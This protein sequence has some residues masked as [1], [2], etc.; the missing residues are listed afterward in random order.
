MSFR[1][2]ES[3]NGA[4]RKEE[5]L[6]Q[7]LRETGGVIVAFSGGVDSTYLLRVAQEEL[8][9]A[10][11][12]LTTSSPTAPQGDEELAR[13]LAREW[14]VTHVVVDANELEIP[15][16]A[17]NPI[18]RCYF[19]KGSLYEI[20]R[21]EAERRGIDTIVDGVNRDDLGDYRPGLTAA[22]EA[23]VVHPLVEADLSKAEIRELSRR[24]G[25]ETAEKPS[26]PC[27]S[28]RFPYGTEITP[29]RLAKVAAAEA[30]LHDHGF[31]ECRVRFHGSMARIE[32]PSEQIAALISDPIRD[33]VW[34]AIRDIG[35]LHVT[36]DLRGFRSGSLNEA[37]GRKPAPIPP[38]ADR[39]P[40]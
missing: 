4:G 23:G 11:V 14:G 15:G 2:K 24:L 1:A 8:G 38:S 30:V 31:R 13:R 36:V 7:R 16:Y 25:L 35:F 12:A 40:S 9:D 27:L 32:V 10:V 26:S 19:C 28:S 18:N 5:I 33:A 34:S 20:C 37:I 17:A 3:D 29:D 6:R 39:R 21:G 22:E